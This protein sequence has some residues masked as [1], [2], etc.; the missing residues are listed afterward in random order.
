MQAMYQGD[1]AFL[2]RY[3]SDLMLLLQVSTGASDR[4]QIGP[5]SM[6]AASPGRTQS[7]LPSIPGLQA[8][9]QDVALQ[10]PDAAHGVGLGTALLDASLSAADDNQASTSAPGTTDGRALAGVLPAA[11]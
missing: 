11:S 2:L 5:P 10:S 4:Q 9:A 6:S 3:L 8:S 7:S 1:D